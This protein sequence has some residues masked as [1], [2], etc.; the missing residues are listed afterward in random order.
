MFTN[1]PTGGECATSGRKGRGVPRRSFRRASMLALFVAVATAPSLLRPQT[2][3]SKLNLYEWMATASTVVVGESL[4][5]SGKYTSV[6][7]TQVFRGEVTEGETI[8]VHVR[9]ANRNRERFQPPLTLEADKSY[10]WLLDDGEPRKRKGRLPFVLVRGT[11]GVRE[12]PSEGTPAFLSAIERFARIQARR[13]DPVAWQSFEE[14]LEETNPVLLQTALDQYLKFRRERPDLLPAL[15]PLFDHPRP[16]VRRRSLTLVGRVLD[17]FAQEK[18]PGLDEVQT[19][20]IAMARRDPSV[21]VRVAATEALRGLRSEGIDRVL[22]EIS[23]ED[24]EQA[25]R[26]A[27]ERLL[28]ER[29]E[30]DGA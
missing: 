20:I 8:P 11:R 22:D 27:A 9:K 25:V 3:S 1:R 19:E 2:G 14:M 10:I 29:G 17:R 12:V 26:Y 18:I 30:E 24:P 7:V 5:E 16:D 21:P 28:F 15:R 13:S 6:R 4:G 23:R